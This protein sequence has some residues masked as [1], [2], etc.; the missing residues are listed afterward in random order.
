MEN[1]DGSAFGSM[2]FSSISQSNIC[3]A[4]WE[5]ISADIIVILFLYIVNKT[6]QELCINSI[7]SITSALFK[8]SP[9]FQ[10]YFMAILGLLVLPGNVLVNMVVA[11]LRLEDRDLILRLSYI[12]LAGLIIMLDFSFWEYSVVQYGL[13]L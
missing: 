2:D 10:G 3:P 7:P 11:N 5:Y 4:C 12:S 13:G 8:T 9:E 6:G 1:G